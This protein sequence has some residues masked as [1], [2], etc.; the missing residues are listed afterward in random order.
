[1]T[2]ATVSSLGALAGLVFAIVMIIF[3]APPFYGLVVGALLG[4]ILGGGG[5]DATVAAMVSGIQ[6]M[7][8][9]I[10]L[11]LTSGVLIGAMIRTGSTEKLAESIIKAFGTK[12]ALFA[13]AF[14]A[15]L[16]CVAGVF[17]DIALIAV[18]PVALAVGRRAN[19]NKESVALAMLG[20]GKAGN[21]ISPNPST[22]ATAEAFN[23]DLTSL[24]GNSL[25]P[26]LAALLIVA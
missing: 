4:G 1:M 25:L 13:I 8:R 10:L 2:P 18:A 9:P 6:G 20:G 24:M 23:V 17:V 16:L 15:A 7:T 11:I 14:A 22:I 26:A 5:L 19:L 3:N 12:R 21:L